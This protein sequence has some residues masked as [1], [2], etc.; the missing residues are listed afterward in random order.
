MTRRLLYVVNDTPYFVLHWLER[1]VAARAHGYDVH[2]AGSGGEGV[3]HVTGVGL[4]HHAV[5]FVRGGVAPVTELVTAA[6]LRA[7][8]RDLRPDI[9]HHITIKPVIYG[10]L[11]SRG[12]RVP[13]AVFTVPG[14][15]YVFSQDG[16]VAAA[17]RGV[18]KLAYRAALAHPR[19]RVIFENPDDLADFE[20]W[21]LVRR[22]QGMVI[23]GAG[24]DLDR[25]HPPAHEDDAAPMVVMASRLLWDKGVGVFVDAARI[26][27]Q[28]R[29]D[30]RMVLAGDNDPASPASIASDQLRRWADEG[31]VEW[32]G[33]RTDMP[34][35][36]AQASV[37]ALPSFYR[38]GIPR[39]LIEAAACG[40]AIV[41]TDTAGCREIVRHGENG[42]LVAPRDP[43]AVAEAI[44][45]LLGDA[46]LRRRMGAAGR[47]RAE[48]EYG[49]PHVIAQTM[50][51]Y[52]EL[53]GHV[54]VPA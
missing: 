40:R 18:V 27:R 4:P 37:V 35:V 9:I 23:K 36:L 52:D 21:R 32:W 53:T 33:R 46:G 15:G 41:T 24:V 29:P 38:E 44:L 51:V 14:L 39:V 22:G 6:R 25:F 13:A 43:V 47:A 8:Y 34:H 7:L 45:A 11:I 20:R 17:R 19:S 3:E 1:A 54:Q 50:A 16:V 2:V 31:I 42:L 26:V 30:A 5:P 48:A 28:R 49:A 10:G 12:G